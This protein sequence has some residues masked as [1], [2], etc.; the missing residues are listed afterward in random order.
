MIGFMFFVVFFI[1]LVRDFW[2][3]VEVLSGWLV[4][5]NGMCGMC[6]VINWMMDMIGSCERWFSYV[7]DG[8]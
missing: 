1:L 2:L 6:V 5:E 4:F 3:R 8:L 7:R